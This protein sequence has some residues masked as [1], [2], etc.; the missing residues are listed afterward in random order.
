M[1]S[2]NNIHFGQPNFVAIDYRFLSE[3]SM[4]SSIN[5][6]VDWIHQNEGDFELHVEAQVQSGRLV[7]V[8]YPLKRA[9]HQWNGGSLT[10]VRLDLLS[11]VS[12]LSTNHY[13][14]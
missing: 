10:D 9:I 11:L 14:V 13:E 8:K 12:H 2:N 7:L 5:V 1:Q 4:H 3:E 6:N